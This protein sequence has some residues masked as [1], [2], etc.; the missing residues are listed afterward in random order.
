MCDVVPSG[1]DL[2]AHVE[3]TLHGLGTLVGDHL[4]DLAHESDRE[5]LTS[6]ERAGDKPKKTRLL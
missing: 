5:P 4:G 6:T 3:P 2:L 1:S